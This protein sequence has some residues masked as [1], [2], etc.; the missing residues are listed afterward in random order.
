M[1]K[2]RLRSATNDESGFTLIEL[3]IV[4]VVLGILAGIVV[5]G[6]STFRTDAINSACAA[7]TKSVN[8][9]SEAFIA[10]TGAAAPNVDALVAAG[11]LKSAP[12]RLT[13]ITIA[14]NG[15]ATG[16]CVTTN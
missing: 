7:D 5:F 10:K 4:I 9:A 6:V 11:Y 3:L 15:T 12:G 1:L 14:A 13:A 8:V 16:T 2:N